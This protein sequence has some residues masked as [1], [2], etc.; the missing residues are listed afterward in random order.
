MG[1]RGLLSRFEKGQ[2]WAK[3]P[4]HLPAHCRHR[5]GLA[6]TGPFYRRPVSHTAP[7]SP[8]LLDRLPGLFL[9]WDGG[10][11]KGPG[12]SLGMHIF[13]AYCPGS[14]L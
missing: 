11:V 4:L 10:W 3:I 13:L 12:S 9:S 2:S 5:R 1:S 14:R 7:K 6:G 8:A